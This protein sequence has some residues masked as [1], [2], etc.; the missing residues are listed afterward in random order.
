MFKSPILSFN[1]YS[2]RGLLRM[3][4]IEVPYIVCSIKLWYTFL[5]I[6][7]TNKK[8]MWRLRRPSFLPLPH[9]F[10]FHIDAMLTVPLFHFSF[11]GDWDP[12]YTQNEHNKHCFWNKIISMHASVTCF[13]RFIMNHHLI[14]S[15]S[16][17]LLHPVWWLQGVLHGHNH[18]L[19]NC[20]LF[21]KGNTFRFSLQ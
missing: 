13:F 7:T 4:L 1:P 11:L 8:E 20:S 3:F 19:L 9:E 10:W 18:N 17:Y 12:L 6:Q 2:T 14:M 5:K 15:T 16:I 21:D